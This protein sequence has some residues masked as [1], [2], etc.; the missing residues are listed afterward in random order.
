[1]TKDKNIFIKNIYYMLSYVFDALRQSTY[2]KISAEEFDNIHSLMAAILSKAIGK[3]L[4]QGLHREYIN[5]AEDVSTARGKIDMSGT[6]KNKI[7]SRRLLTCRYDV[8][9]ENNLLNQILKTTVMTLLR[10]TKVD[11]KYKNKLKR[12][13]LFFS[14]V[15]TLSPNSIKWT[16]VRF[17]RNS[18]S[19]QML[20]SLCQLILKG[21]LLTTDEGKYKLTN[22]LDERRMCQLYEKF[23]LEY[24]KKEHPKLKA[25]SSQI[26]WS[27]D[28]NNNTMLPIM[29]S[30]VTLTHGSKVLIIDA[31]YYTHTTNARYSLRTVHSNNLYQIFSYVKNKNCEFK[32]SQH[33]V[34]GLLLYAGT[35]ESVQPDTT[36]M[37]SGNKISVTT[38]NLN[39]NF[40][41]IS[42]KLDAIA[43]SHFGQI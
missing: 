24:Y 41:E 2:D 33:E 7:S 39:Q 5:H 20:I 11:T 13:M 30:D 17:Q 15:D 40:K 37:M 26:P 22:F 19:Y 16:S 34:S 3:Q 21:M 43:A 8:L 14:D 27:L 25:N 9:S 42:S 10:H 18:Q 38:L 32:N 23:I 28:D 35:N 12:E 4:K 31:K 29:Q 36:Y 1:M 6:I